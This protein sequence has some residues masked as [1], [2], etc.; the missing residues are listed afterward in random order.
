MGSKKYKGKICAYCGPEGISSTGDHIFA[1]GFFLD[2]RRDNIPQVPSCDS[3]NN[4]KSELEHYLT[5][6]L[7]FGG[8]HSDSSEN[9]ATMVPKRLNKNGRLHRKLYDLRSSGWSRTEQGLL[10]RSMTLPI[11]F[12]KL[13]KLMEY[14]LRGLAYKHMGVILNKDDNVKALALTDEGEQFFNNRLF[15]VRVKNRIKKSWG[16]GTIVYEGVQGV[17][18][19]KVTAWKIAMY[20]GIQLSEDD[21][22]H[23]NSSLFGGFTS[24]RRVLDNVRRRIMFNV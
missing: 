4:L 19:P 11:D 14:I 24:D 13:E 15:G 7:P 3:C 16:R 18:D 10:V 1:R 23:S 2:S 22:S 6:L 20:G 8:Q 9:L 12:N 5:A 21:G 17:D